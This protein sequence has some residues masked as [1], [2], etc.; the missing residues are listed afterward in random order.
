MNEVNRSLNQTD[1]R[2]KKT[3]TDRTFIQILMSPKLKAI[4]KDATRQLGYGT[5]SEF[6]RDAIRRR[7]EE[8]GFKIDKSVLAS[9]VE[10]P[11]G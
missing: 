2:S 3:K 10:K 6:G 1:H 9:G 5:I 8:L 7:L 4:V 11:I